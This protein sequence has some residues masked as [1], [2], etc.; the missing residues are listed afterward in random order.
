MAGE[1]PVESA[2]P[3]TLEF[4]IYNCACK[5]LASARYHR[6]QMISDYPEGVR[7]L[8]SAEVMRIYAMRRH[9][10]LATRKPKQVQ[11]EKP[12]HRPEWSDFV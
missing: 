11:Y 4:T 9:N 7:E 12:V 6:E 3:R 5:V 2:E 1:A 8:V 10:H